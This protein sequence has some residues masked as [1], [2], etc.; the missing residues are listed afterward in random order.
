MI[1]KLLKKFGYE[2]TSNIQPKIEQPKKIRQF[3]STDSLRYDTTE[4]INT[5]WD[6]T[7]KNAVHP[8][9]A[10][11]TQNQKNGVTYAMDSQVNIKAPYQ[12]N[13]NLPEVQVLWYAGQTFI[14]YQLCAIL[15]QQWLIGK[16]CLM[17]AKD[18]TRNGYEIT[19]ND[20]VE[21]APEILDEIRKQ[22][23]HYKINKN[24]IQFVQ[25][26]RVF[27]IRVAMFV[28]ESDDPE[29][30]KNPF[31]IDG[32]LPGSYRGISQ[33]DPYWI[34]PQLDDQAA[35]NPASINFYE[36]TWWIINGRPVH[37]THLIIFRTE[38][39]SDIL[40][41][42]YIYGGIPIP[43]KIAN[44]V[45]ASEAVANEAP[46]LAM[47]KR[48]DV[49]N[50]DLTEMLAN[51][52]ST[53]ARIQQW[54]F[55]RDNYG[56]KTLGLEEDMKQF[57]TTLTDLDSVIMTQYQLVAAAANVPAVKLLGTSPKGFNATGEFEEANYHEE[58]ESIQ[59]HDLSPLL[60]RHHL[61]LIKSE[62]APKFNIE[63]FNTTVR[64][65]KLDAMTEK[66]QAELN[67]FNAETGL[68]L[69]NSGAIDA[70]DERNRIMADPNSGYTGLN[71]D[72]DETG[73]EIL[74][75]L[76]GA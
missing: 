4:K 66:E 68:F 27:G 30:Y 70:Q 32:V 6:Q 55:N 56:I 39:V 74:N 31:N 73:E 57:D 11:A 20:G 37:R 63:P 12:N 42:S 3:L 48:T 14:G 10:T 19:V 23:V 59:Y 15:S 38:E 22:D 26:G 34:T 29:Y 1:K 64:W 16:C 9:I 71:D 75:D 46:M 24:L 43:Q 7:F 25:M 65:N 45:F 33:I 35:G 40:K 13:G 58:L 67:K 52:Q 53:E 41:P 76:E 8:S 69:I 2:K 60:E 21:V 49:L 18:A 61:L 72:L 44:R 36:P 51:Q 17:P 5:L 50:V 28:V 54:V 47:T 62:I